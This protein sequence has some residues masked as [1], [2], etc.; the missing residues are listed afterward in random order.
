MFIVFEGIDGSGKTT[1]INLL[2]EYLEKKNYKVWLTKEPT[3]SKI[4]K[5]IREILQEG[6]EINEIWGKIMIFLFTADRYY[7]QI[8]IREKLKENYIVISDRYYH[9]TFA[10][11]IMY[12]GSSIE[13]LKYLYKDLIKPDYVFVLDVPV[14]I[15]LERMSERKRKHMYERKEFLEKVRENYLKLKEI[16]P[17][18][19]IYIIDNK[20]EPEKTLKEII[21]ILKL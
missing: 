3:D 15:A 9:S 11:Q 20:K 8:E 4:G 12:P 21:E 17:D 13:F 14:E 6:H 10:Y 1:I 19:N 16:L 2:K 18:E 7:H 5:L